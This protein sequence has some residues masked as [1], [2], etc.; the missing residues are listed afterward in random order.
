MVFYRYFRRKGWR[1]FLKEN[2]LESEGSNETKAKSIALGIFIGV[3]PFWGFH[4][5]LAITLSVYFKLNKLLTFMSSQITIPP[6]I[7][8]IIFLSVMIGAKVLGIETSFENI[9]FDMDFVKNNLFLYIVGSLI[10]ATVSAS[11]FGLI[12]Y[13][14]MEKFNPKKK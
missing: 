10:L 5:F 1:R 7:P 13:F 11:F 2:I 9:T 8:F 12:S 4:S 14:L 6:L 3:S